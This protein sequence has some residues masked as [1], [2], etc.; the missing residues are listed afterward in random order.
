MSGG[1]R[2]AGILALVIAVTAGL[3]MMLK[4][5]NLQSLVASLPK[6]QGIWKVVALLLALLNLKNLPFVWHVS[7]IPH[8]ISSKG[9]V[10]G[11]I[12]IATIV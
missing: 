2:P 9:F 1:Q 5:D 10:L 6:S 7:A 11:L 12:C 8:S 3:T 4:V